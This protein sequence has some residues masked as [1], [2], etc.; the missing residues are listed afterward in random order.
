VH[1]VVH[2]AP[3]SLVDH[4]L[5]LDP[6]APDELSTLDLKSKM[7]F[8]RGIVA[9]VPAMLFAIVPEMDTTR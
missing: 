6:R 2:Q 1:P 8:A 4:P 3:Q 9:P 5:T 7:A